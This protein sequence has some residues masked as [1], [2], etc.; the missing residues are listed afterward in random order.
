[1]LLGDGISLELGCQRRVPPKKLLPSV[2]LVFKRLHI[3]TD[4]QLIITSTGNE[5]FRG[6]IIIYL[7]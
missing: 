1:M 7:D 5:L 4:M 2:S 6:I 3:S